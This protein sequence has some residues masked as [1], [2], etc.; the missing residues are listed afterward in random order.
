M[1]SCKRCGCVRKILLE[2]LKIFYPED[3]VGA[4]L[5]CICVPC[6]LNFLNLQDNRGNYN[7]NKAME[8]AEK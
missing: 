4:P 5:Y 7:F 3:G 1:K 8:I 6:L 2:E